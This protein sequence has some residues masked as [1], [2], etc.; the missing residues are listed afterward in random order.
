MWQCE[1]KLNRKTADFRFSSVAL[2]CAFWR[3]ISS[4][5]NSQEGAR[6]VTARKASLENKHMFTSDCLAII[7]F[8]TH[9]QITVQ[10]DWWERRR[11]KHS[12]WKIYCYVC[13]LSLKPYIWKFSRC[14]LADYV[15][16]LCYSAYRTCSTIIFPHSTNQIIVFW[17]RLCCCRRPV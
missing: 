1:G 13:T 3:R 11:I 17:R 8:C 5:G 4:G 16:E 12:E 9:W 7:A 14:H 2:Y 6:T 10:V 15:K